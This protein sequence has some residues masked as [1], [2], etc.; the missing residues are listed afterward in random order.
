MKRIVIGLAAIALFAAPMLSYA[1]QQQ[2]YG[3]GDLDMEYDAPGPPP[4]NDVEDGQLLILA[5]YIAMPFGWLLEHGVTRPLHELATDSAAAPFLSGDTEIKYFGESSN[6]SLLPPNTFRP[7]QM[8][9]NPN[10][11]DTGDTADNA[12]ASPVT[13][14]V[15]SASAILPPV[16]SVQT[17]TSRTTGPTTAN[18]YGPYGA[19][20]GQPVIH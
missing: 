12:V 3:A 4:Y 13:P 5:S 17:I 8:P 18:P 6:A 15:S 19:P 11:M 10:S 7:F 2:R 20:S 14:A 9:A 16:P 1:Q